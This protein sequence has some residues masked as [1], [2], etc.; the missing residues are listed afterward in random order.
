MESKILSFIKQDEKIVYNPTV[1]FEFGGKKYIGVRVES[2]GSESDSRILFAYE[3]DKNTN[4]WAIDYSLGSLPLQDSAYVKINGKTFILGV[5][6]LQNENGIKYKQDIYK[7][8][9]IKNLKYFT[10]GPIGMKDI[11]LVD[12]EDRIG[13]F[14]RPKGKI[15]GKGKIGYLEV[16]SVDELEDFTEE[17]WY[18]A[19]IIE[20]LFDDGFWGGVNQA[21]KLPGGDI[22][23][24]GHIAH[25]T[26]NEKS[27]LE[28]HYFGM[29]FRFN[30]KTYK[31]SEFKIIA[32]RSD[33][34]PAFSKRS[35]ELNDIVFPAGI[36]N[37]NNLYCGLSDFC[38]GKKKI[39]NPF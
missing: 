28:K 4:L 24:I 37:L 23:V 27:E 16:G 22:G 9:S 11:R 32:K 3:Q 14:T 12:L 6:V 34:P 8:D 29:A 1:P 30:P 36:D 26:I 18:N 31:S 10:S 25:Q 7:G 20:G 19:K 35:P 33:F 2:L 17:D 39:Q 13:V 38:V 5:R 21:I 15:G